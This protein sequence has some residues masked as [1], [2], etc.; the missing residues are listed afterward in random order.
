MSLLSAVVQPILAQAPAAPAGNPLLQLLPF[1]FIFAAM[2]FFMIAPQ[3]K[4]QK[5][6]E[7]MLKSLSPGDEIIT[8][9]GMYG[10]VTSV[11]EDRFIVRVSDTTK[12]EI[13]KNFVHAVLS[14]ADKLTEE[15]K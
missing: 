13:G 6:H 11:K 12:I 4:K 2:Y 9:G 8:A 5:E 15:K 14:K 10:T 7:K 1:L 3:R